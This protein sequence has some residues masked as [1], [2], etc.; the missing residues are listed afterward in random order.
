MKT[1]RAEAR[2]KLRIKVL[3]PIVLAA[4]FAPCAFGRI[5]D[6]VHAA[7]VDLPG[8]QATTRTAD[9]V[10]ASPVSVNPVSAKPVAANPILIVREIDDPHS[11]VR[12]LLL[13]DPQHP[14]GPGRLVPAAAVGNERMQ[15]KAEGQKAEAPQQPVIRAGEKLIIEEHSPSIDARLE[16]IALN[17][18]VVG[19]TLTARLAIGGRVVR[20]MAV[21]PGRALLAPEKEGWQ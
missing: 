1:V 11:G 18:A 6:E 19:G 7:Q 12:W 9:P 16:A 17:P 10:S 21:A 2:I 5:A 3:A 4:V 8:R 15:S 20:A 13:I 14:G